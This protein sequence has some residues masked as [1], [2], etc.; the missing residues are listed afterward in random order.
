MEQYNVCVRG[1]NGT[2]RR[3][4]EVENGTKRRASEVKMEQND[5]RQSENGTKRRASEVKM[6]QNDVLLAPRL[7]TPDDVHELCRRYN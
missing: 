6:E 5:V 3:A 2:K 4:S 1:E 7:L